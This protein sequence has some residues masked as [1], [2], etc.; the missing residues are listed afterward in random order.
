[1]GE[2][3]EEKKNKQETVIGGGGIGGRKAATGRD[4]GR[5]GRAER[6]KWEGE[7]QEGG[8]RG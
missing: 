2:E 4:E 7:E 8:S 3:Q 6:K 5:G 1:M